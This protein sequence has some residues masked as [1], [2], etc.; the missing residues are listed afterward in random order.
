MAKKKS[1][2][3]PKV[4]VALKGAGANAIPV[5]MG[6]AALQ[7]AAGE[8]PLPPAI[9]SAEQIR[10][11]NGLQSVIQSLAASRS[12]GG[13]GFA[14]YGSGAPWSEQLSQS[15]T[16][17]VNL[18]WY[19]VSNFR[20]MLSEAYAELGLVQTICKVPVEDALRGGVEIQC[21][22]LSEDEIKELQACVDRHQDL[23]VVGQA[24]IWNR[25]YGGSAILILTDQ[26]PEKP[27]KLSSLT[28]SSNVEFRAIDMWEL[29]W[30]L[31]ADEGFDAETQTENVEYYNYYGVNV[32]KSRVRRLKGITA[33]SFIRPRLR[34]WG[35]S[36]V[37]VLVRSINQY[38]KATDLAFEVLDEFKLDVYH[39]ENLAASMMDAQGEELVKRR[40]SLTNWLKNFQ[41][42]IVLDKNDEYDSKQL[43]FTGIGEVM[44]QIRMQVASD[45]RIPM[46]KLFGISAT[47]FN[48][49]EDDIEV[50]NAMVES[51]VRNKVKYDIVHLLEIRC[52]QLFG[53]IP[54][55]LTIGFKPLRVLGAE[56]EENVKT[57]K[58][59][60]L[61]QATQAGLIN[62]V[63][64]REGVN[65]GN[66]LE[67]QL[68]PTLGDLNAGA[69]ADQAEGG[70]DEEA[71]ADVPAPKASKGKNAAPGAPTARTL[72][73]W[74]ESKHPRDDDGKF[75]EGG[76]SG[77]SSVKSETVKKE[78]AKKHK[79]SGDFDVHSSDHSRTD[80][81][82]LAKQ[83]R[84]DGVHASIWHME[85]PKTG[86]KS[87]YAVT[88]PLKA[89]NSILFMPTRYTRRERFLRKFSNSIEFDLA[90]YAA[91]GGDQ[92]IDPR[93]KELFLDPANVDEALWARAREASVKGFGRVKWQFVTW[94]YKKQGGRFL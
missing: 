81:V 8:Q 27:L 57:Q 89:K 17:F 87:K 47:G 69:N 72:N 55:S 65:R 48:S 28:D 32:H 67:I 13:F 79:L 68:D 62:G 52:Q 1:S 23:E 61:L 70:E 21:P 3:T 71:D 30:D 64:F 5:A 43:S 80:A 66:L 76:G 34:G 93:R 44:S 29:F 7:N 90:A 40:I 26:D 14:G 12:G 63:E 54:E 35:L 20:Q 75:G 84:K 9:K 16:M 78:L 92:W 46:T 10:V 85:G 91:D 51:D 4:T 53:F 11:E 45:M 73:A 58:F 42:A 6:A 88:V 37:E 49:G 38:L 83:L 41:K 18:R 31:Q 77:G 94:L 25:L 74:D 50:Y 59:N 22:E 24:S 56:Q 15:T 86:A 39:M 2:P 33:P 60:R 36:V 19:L 82:K